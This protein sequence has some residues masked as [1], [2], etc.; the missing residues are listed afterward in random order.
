MHV[1]EEQSSGTSASSKNE[2]QDLLVFPKPSIERFGTSRL[3]FKLSPSGLAL[4]SHYII[5]KSGMHPATPYEVEMWEMIREMEVEIARLAGSSS[6]PP[7]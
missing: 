2:P 1:S 5:G 3:S 4:Y 6:F 7:Q